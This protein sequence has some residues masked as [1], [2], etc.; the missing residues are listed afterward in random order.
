MPELYIF[1]DESGTM[2]AN[3]KDNSFVAAT[4]TFLDKKPLI[5][6]GSDKNET[7]IKIFKEQSA[8]PFATVV[9]PF[10]GYA[11]ALTFL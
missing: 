4:V 7:L 2:P 1:G 10:P 3:D 11:K 5:T 6:N 9:N 8:I